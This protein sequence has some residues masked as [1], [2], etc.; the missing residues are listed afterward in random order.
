MR[1]FAFPLFL[2]F[3]AVGFLHFS[4]VSAEPLELRAELLDDRVQVLVGDQLFTEYQFGDD[5]KYPQ[6][7]PVQGPRSETSVTTRRSDPYPHHSSLFFGCDKVNGG[8]YWQEGLDRGRIVSKNVRL[9]QAAGTE[10]L[11][12]Q[13]C[14]WERP[15]AEPPFLDSR[16]IAIRAPSPDRRIID[17]SI[18][19]AALTDV[20][21]KKTNHSLFA[22]RIAPDLAVTAGG[23]L[24]N[25][26]GQQGE[27]ASFGQPSAWMDARGEREQG[28][29]GLAI[30]VH[31]D[32]PWTPTPWFTRDYGF[33]SPTP[34][35]WIDESFHMTAG[36][37]LHLRYRVLVHAD[38][39][40]PADLQIVFDSWTSSK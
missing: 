25:E 18:T 19:L 15:G 22:A 8:N 23:K 1:V 32:N 2:L 7:Y 12:Q 4:V 36:A 14:R 26:H 29:E 37:T 35:Y 5:L 31:P 24:I 30:F 40:S 9:L 6:F 11:I 21:I 39:P 33:F 34:F 38:D 28:T 20:T 17:F 3:A 13:E 16:I 27:K 10:I